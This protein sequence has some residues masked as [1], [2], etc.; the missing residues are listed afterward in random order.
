MK[1]LTLSFLFSFLFNKYNTGN[2]EC[3]S[4]TAEYKAQ[5]QGQVFEEI[6]GKSDGKNGFAKVPQ[7][8]GNKFFG[9]F[10][11]GDTHRKLLS[12][13]TIGEKQ[14]GGSRGSRMAIECLNGAFGENAFN[15][16]II[17]SEGVLSRMRWRGVSPVSLLN[18]ESGRVGPLRGESKYINL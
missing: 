17:P 10:F 16:G 7:I 3:N 2:Q 9:F 6:T 8:L 12:L 18:I 4:E 13:E 5:K 11:N 14:F 1:Q 15:E